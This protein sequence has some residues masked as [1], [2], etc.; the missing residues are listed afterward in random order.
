M[1]ER[2]FVDFVKIC[3]RSGSGG[4]GSSHFFRDRLQTKGG[5]DGGDG[6]RGG[7][8]ILRANPQLWTLLHLKYRKHVKATDGASGGA[9]RRSGADGDDIVLD[10]PL[11]TVAK[12]AETGELILEVTEADQE[13]ILLEGGKGGL[14]NTHFKSPTN[15]S[16]RYAQPGIAGREK[17]IILELK[18]LADVG[19]VGYPNAGKSTLLSAVSAAKPKIAD[20]AFTTLAPN[21]GIVGH[22]ESRSFVMADIPGIIEDAHLGKG[23]GHRFL[24]HIERNSL[25]L[26]VIPADAESIAAD[27]EVLTRELALYNPELIFKPRLL[28]ISK[29]DLIDEELRELIDLELPQGIDH[30]YFS[31]ITSEGIQELKDAIWSVLNG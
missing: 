1:S 22:R 8:I 23:L 7:H 17:W 5:P 18:L 6:G 2:N 14:G 29:S 15:Q 24:R 9:S 16:P 3:C 20:Y 30:V 19:L 13:Y 12:D 26:F 11:G 31:S 21:L 28:G 4:P 25:L 27:Y 10:V